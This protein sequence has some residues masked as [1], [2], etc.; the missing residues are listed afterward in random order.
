MLSQLS[1]ARDPATARFLLAF[2]Q[3]E[4]FVQRPGEERRAIYAALASVAGDEIVSELE[5][6]L[7]RGNWFDRT[8]EIH[9]HN[10]A[11]C[12]ARIGTP[13]ARAVLERGAQSRRAQVRHASHTAMAILKEAA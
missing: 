9:R 3:N 1:G 7:F 5:A 12:L 10:I 4:R 11:R 13:S 8:Q 2:V 6:E